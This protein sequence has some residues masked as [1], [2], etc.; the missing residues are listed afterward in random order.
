SLAA[1]ARERAA[2]PGGGPAE[3]PGAFLASQER[4]AAGASARSG[5]GQ[6]STPRRNLGAGA[7]LSGVVAGAP[8]GA[9]GVLS[10]VIART[11]GPAGNG[12][13]ALL[14]TFTGLTAIVVSLGLSTG[15]TYEVSRGRWAVRHAFRTSYI[16]ALLLGLVG[17]LGGLGF[18]VLTHDS[19]FK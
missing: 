12:H 14:V 2:R 9:A 4:G 7:A 8:V 18:F 16:A 3:D 17:F 19:V 5:G 1:L 10:I 13:L 6:L 11:V 15:I